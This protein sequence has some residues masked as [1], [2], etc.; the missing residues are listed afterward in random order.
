MNGPDLAD[1]ERRLTRLE[2]WTDSR[3]VTKDVFDI[4]IKNVV[5][6]LE[7][8]EEN[9]RWLMRFTVMALVGVIINIVVVAITPYG[10]DGPYRDRP[11]TDFTLQAD[12]GA[13]AIRGRADQAPYQMGGRTGAWLAGAYA[14]AAALACW[15]GRRQGG[16]GALVDLSLDISDGESASPA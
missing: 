5:E 9:D 3:L 14:A 8:G 16:H 4:S 12:S 2:A 15:E 6:R 7:K 10:L 1:H 13:L 11:A